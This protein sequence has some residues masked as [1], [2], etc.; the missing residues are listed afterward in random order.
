ME[1]KIMND[2]YRDFFDSNLIGEESAFKIEDVEVEEN[3]INIDDLY[4]TDE[5]KELLK[6]IIL[7]MEKYNN[8]EESNYIT[9]NITLEST[10]KTTINNIGNLLK[11]YVELYVQSTMKKEKKDELQDIVNT[12]KKKK[13]EVITKEKEIV[14]GVDNKGYYYTHIVFDNNKMILN[15]D[16]FN[17]EKKLYDKSLYEDKKELLDK[18]YKFSSFEKKRII[19]VNSMFQLDSCLCSLIDKKVDI[20]YPVDKIFKCAKEIVDIL[21]KELIEIPL[22]ESVLHNLMVK[23]V[24]AYGSKRKIELYSKI[25]DSLNN[26]LSSS[27]KFV[28]DEIVNSSRELISDYGYNEFKNIKGI[29]PVVDDLYDIVNNNIR[30]YVVKNV[31]SIIS[32][33]SCLDC[34]TKYMDV[35]KIVDIY[36]IMKQEMIGLRVS[37]SKY[38]LLQSKVVSLLVDRFSIDED[39]VY[40]EYLNEGRMS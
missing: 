30:Q 25:I 38:V 3:I 22:K 11:Y 7:Y 28:Y 37:T 19:Y 16:S 10:D 31:S 39:V 18:K 23:S 27:N 24:E 1:R 26:T 4:I 34:Y 2:V 15:S 21:Y 5:S 17:E 8:K 29:F 33:L 13:N 20:T 40:T 12:I 9:F 14:Y 32:N 36:N 35:D 6:K